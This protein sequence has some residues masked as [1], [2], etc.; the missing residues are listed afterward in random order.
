MPWIY[1]GSLAL[2]FGTLLVLITITPLDEYLESTLTLHMV[3]Q[4]FLFIAAGFLFCY[5]FDSFILALSRISRGVSNAYTWF[6]RV[7]S[8]FNK[9]GVVTFIVAALLIAYWNLPSN[10]DAAVFNEGTHIVMHSTFLVVGGLVFIGAKLL[11]KRVQ[12]IAPIIAGKAMGLFG[13]FLLI[14]PAYVYP[15][16]SIADQA[17]TGVVMVVMMLVMD[18]TIVP[19]WLYDY[20]GKAPTNSLPR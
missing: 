20:F 10:F 8:N 18:L 2:A 16:Y 6:L 19:L 4:H 7:N 13:V 11:T 9:W 5:G 1:R 14:T 15:A 17:V 12:H 3:A